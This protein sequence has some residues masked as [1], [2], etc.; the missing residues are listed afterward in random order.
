[1]GSLVPRSFIY[2]FKLP[3]HFWKI[4]RPCRE[5]ERESEHIFHSLKVFSAGLSVSQQSVVIHKFAFGHQ[6]HNEIN[7]KSTA[8]II[9]HSKV[10][11]NLLTPINQLLFFSLENSEKLDS[12]NFLVSSLWCFQFLCKCNANYDSCLSKNVETNPGDD[13]VIVSPL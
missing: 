7:K 9:Q 1:M 11:E 13:F 2:I 3:E 5:K 6:N 4:K 12:L 10:K 8:E